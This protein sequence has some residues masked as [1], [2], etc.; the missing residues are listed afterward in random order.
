MDPPDHGFYTAR[1]WGDRQRGGI[2][3][4]GWK[5]SRQKLLGYSEHTTRDAALPSGRLPWIFVW[6]K[7]NPGPV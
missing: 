1:V 7:M 3:A 2:R 6:G 5:T 4:D